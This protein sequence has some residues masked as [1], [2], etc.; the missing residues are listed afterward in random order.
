MATATKALI[1]PVFRVSFAHVFKP[2]KRDDDKKVWS[3]TGIFDPKDPGLK[4]MKEM[5][6]A[7]ATIKWPKKKGW[8]LP[9]R[10]GVE[11]DSDNSRGFDLDKYPEYANKVIVKMSSYGRPIKLVYNRI[12]EEGKRVP[13]EDEADFYSGCYARAA[14]SCFT[15]AAAGNMGVSFGI[16][17]IVKI[18]DGEPLINVADPTK[19][20]AGI[21]PDEYN[22]DN[23]SEFGDD[24]L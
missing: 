7:C 6:I 4:E 22:T 23:S 5:A 21:K 16:T 15:Y 11:K 1:T 20:F 24:D 8:V 10:K 17:S 14:V 3:I 12:D 2:E 19:D 9:F 13:I 18:K